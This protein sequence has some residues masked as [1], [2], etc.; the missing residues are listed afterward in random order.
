M[1]RKRGCIAAVRAWRPEQN[2]SGSA[3]LAPIRQ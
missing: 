1:D 2:V 3:H